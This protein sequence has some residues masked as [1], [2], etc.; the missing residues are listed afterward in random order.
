[1]LM[2]DDGKKRTIFSRRSLLLSGLNGLMFTA[3]VT[4]VIQLQL[5]ESR[6]YSIMSN[7][8][9]LRLTIVPPARGVIYSR[10][11]E[12]IAGNEGFTRLAINDR[13]IK[14]IMAAIGQLNDGILRNHIS[15]TEAQVQNLI[16]KTSATSPVVIIPN[17]A[18]EDLSNIEFYRY[19]LDNVIVENAHRRFYPYGE[20]YA[21]V[22]GYVASPT[23]DQLKSSN[24]INHQDFVI[25]KN[26]L[27][28]VL[29][30]SLYGTPGVKEVETNAK[31][32]VMR[33]ISDTNSIPGNEVYTSLH[34]GL[35]Q[36]ISKLFNGKNGGCVVLDIATGHVLA[37][38][39]APSFDPN[40][41]VSGISHNY[42]NQL[43]NN[44]D[45][46]LI[47]K[48]ISG[49]FPPGSTFKPVTALAAL[50]AGIDPDKTLFCN[51]EHK[52]G[53][54]IFHC[55]KRS[56]HGDVDMRLA[57]AQSCNVYFYKVAQEIGMDNIANVADMLGLGS[58]SGID[59]PFEV[60]GLIPT[61]KW[62]KRYLKQDWM[63][64]DTANAAIGQ[65][66]VLTT[67][68]QLAVMIARIASGK[69]VIP[70]LQIYDG[71][72]FDDL[73]ISANSLKVVREGMNMG[74]NDQRGNNYIHRLL[75]TKFAMS[76]KTGTAQVAALSQSKGN[77][78][79]DEHGLFVGFAPYDAPRYAISCIVEHGV[80]GS[81]SALP[82]A[83][84]VMLYLAEHGIN[85]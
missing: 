60:P 9:R 38:Y 21:H 69:K 11:G 47:N 49:A 17:L 74:I 18:W 15:L 36:E 30:E 28:K 53:S 68:I 61:K 76:G 80:W 55:F 82:I 43:L 23:E 6:K 42:W 4:R 34:L 58:L 78:R 63:L 16:R 29:N 32:N 8:N 62:K 71:A 56:G 27:E 22:I 12:I 45:K 24:I 67:P 75:D 33:P 44:P 64:G 79:L 77:S 5:F 39:S 70:S 85:K 35:Q 2:R 14:V 59:L 81:V 1:M 46:P 65:G 13:R 52:V 25:G 66:Y 19:K 41:F 40:Q 26:G 57:I 73:A 51:G 37:M 7:K 54:R 50:Y 48:C 20:L 10:N 3:L 72:S 84:Q 83:K 31:G